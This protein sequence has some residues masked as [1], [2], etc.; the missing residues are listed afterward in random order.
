MKACR[1]LV[2]EV[3]QTSAMDCGP[4]CL[5]SLLEGFGIPVAY[6]RLREVC[7]TELD[8][9]SI[10]TI[11][12]VAND[13][14][15]EAEQI[16]VPVDHLLQAEAAILPAIVVVRLPNGM[17]HFVIAWRKWGRRLQVMDPAQGRRWT[18]KRDFLNT[19]HVHGQ[20]VAAADW[21]EWAA[22]DAF[23]R[24]LLSRIL[25]LGLTRDQAHEL[26][27]AAT[28]ES[29]WRLLAALDAAVRMM[30]PVIR[31]GK[32]NGDQV[33]SRLLRQF[34]ER[35]VAAGKPL[36]VIPPVYWSVLPARGYTEDRPELIFRGA[37]LVRI[38]GKKADSETFAPESSGMCESDAGVTATLKQVPSGTTARLVQFLRA[39]GLLT[40]AA[41]TA[42][43][44]LSSAC[45]LFEA[46]LFRG[47]ID[48]TGVLGLAQQRLMTAGMLLSFLIMLLAFDVSIASSLLRMGRKLEVRLR[49]HLLQALPGLSD[50]YF[51][52]RLVSDMAERSH[53]IH[54]IRLLPLVG[55][56]LIRYAA[57]L[58]MTTLAVIW[59]DPH[60]AALAIAAALSATVLP[61]LT[62]PFI[63]ERDLRF[64]THAGALCRFYLDALRGLMPIRAHAAETAVRREHES[65][66]ASW[67]RAG[68]GVQRYAVIL[69]GISMMMGSA[70]IAWL[71]L[72]HI[73]RSTDSTVALLLIYWSLQIPVLGGEVAQVAWQYPRLHNLARRLLEPVG[74]A[75]I[76]ETVPGRAAAEPAPDKLR[77]PRSGISIEFENVS[78]RTAGHTILSDFS[79]S[80][81]AGSHV[82]I[83]GPSG[84]GKSSFVGLLLGWHRP[85][86][87]RMLIDGR[88]LEDADL[89]ML[90]LDTAWVDPGVHIWNRSLFENLHYG[91]DPEAP[92]VPVA[93]AIDTAELRS[94]M[95]SLR[96][97]LQT[98]LGESGA[99]V[100]GG[101]GQ[102][103][104][105][106][107]AMLR[108]EPRLV[109]LDEAFSG[110]HRAARSELLRRTR[111]M[112]QHA[113]LL[114]V[115]HDIS[116]SCEFERVLV[117][118][119]G[120]VVQD[121]S[122]AALLRPHDSRYRQLLAAEDE[123]RQQ[124][125]SDPSWR[126]IQ[127][128]NGRLNEISDLHR[129]DDHTSDN[130][131]AASTTGRGV[132]GSRSAEWISH[133]G[134]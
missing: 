96:D 119:N 88:P 98:R 108:P 9:T 128:H 26:L 38:R 74:M 127:L 28:A 126:T 20:C 42:A 58:A 70:L 55:A 29:H 125:W 65:L 10:D 30:A 62:Q 102:R 51:G 77:G 39:D 8:G 3:V 92:R 124:V 131:L 99:L 45:L 89:E 60:T 94:V 123:V 106:G 84:A 133:S 34:F 79:L 72:G 52:S 18:L 81:P 11:E 6:D 64:R 115:T 71:L 80:I 1:F 14:G 76:R 25:Q 23:M 17:T 103:V 78:V 53:A 32:L 91:L 86:T 85:A 117:V 73:L 63:A 24:P 54:E 134:N 118:E 13:S 35:A 43:L 22:T 111:Q 37:V 40:P 97:G 121:G 101:E 116:E 129:Y 59:L 12:R 90:R 83:V 2:P 48:L 130:I 16:V 7:Q 50:R 75:D 69:E 47:F 122:P 105:L 67:A 104:R 68:L 109:I 44:L 56:R 114:C 41:I 87:G 4:A 21:H 27:A 93:T 5:K 113:T 57:Q 49:A 19:V 46:V 132:A 95:T 15:L 66:L 100:S 36:R 112:W 120:H 82:C 31:S 110:L 107:R 61:F 33:A